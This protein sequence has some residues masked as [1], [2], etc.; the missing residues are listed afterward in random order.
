MLGA[1]QE[2]QGDLRQMM[3]LRQQSAEYQLSVYPYNGAQYVRH[4]DAFPDDGSEGHQRRVQCSPQRSSVLCLSPGIRVPGS[5]MYGRDAWPEICILGIS[6]SGMQEEIFQASL[7]LR[8]GKVMV[9][10]HAT[11]LGR[12]SVQV[13]AIL[14]ANPGWSPSDGGKLRLWPPPMID[15]AAAG[16]ASVHSGHLPLGELV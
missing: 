15:P 12:C 7:M 11:R 16:P 14:Y 8:S 6:V 10:Y 13:T 9:L 1:A 5:C 2:L 3:H 4:R